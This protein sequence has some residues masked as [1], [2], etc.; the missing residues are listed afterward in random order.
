[1]KGPAYPAGSS[2]SYDRFGNQANPA[3]D[4]RPAWATIGLV[5][6]KYLL[7]GPMEMKS[8]EHYLYVLRQPGRVSLY[9]FA[10]ARPN[11]LTSQISNLKTHLPLH[12]YPLQRYTLWKV[13]LVEMRVDF[14][15]L[16][17]H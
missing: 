12:L 15:K 11:T 16:R 6:S 5:G 4:H 10:P 1:M 8:T 14:D 2:A 9:D 13:K 17:Q 7:V 3:P